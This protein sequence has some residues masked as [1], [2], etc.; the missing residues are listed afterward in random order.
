MSFVLCGGRRESNPGLRGARGRVFSGSGGGA[1]PTTRMK[2]SLIAY[3]LLQCTAAG[4]HYL[5]FVIILC[6]QR[7]LTAI[8]VVVVVVAGQ[9][10]PLPPTLDLRIMI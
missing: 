7:Y 8:V 5:Y 1:S 6:K 2:R 3:D 4:Y 9:S 10:F